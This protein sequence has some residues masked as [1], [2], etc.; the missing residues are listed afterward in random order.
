MAL[1]ATSYWVNVTRAAIVL[2]LSLSMAARAQAAPSCAAPV[3]TD[4]EWEVASPATSGLDPAML[5]AIS[6]RFTAWSAANIHAVLVSRHGKLVF[7]QYFTGA[8]ERLGH[9]AGLIA[10]DATTKHDL[11]SISKSVTALVLGIE[12][13]KRAIGGIDQPVLAAFP[14][15]ADLRSPEK[16]RVTLRHLLTMSSGLAWNEDLPYSNPAN[17]ETR[18]DHAP[19]P[20]RFALEQPVEAPAGAVYNYDSGSTI[21]IAALLKKATGKPID[22]LARDD[23]FGPLGITD[24]EWG[25]FP[26]GEP[27]AASGLRMRPRDLMKIGQLVLDHGAWKG[28]QIVPDDWLAAATSPQIQGQQLYFYGYQFWLGRSLVRGRTIEWVASVGW[29]GQR[30]FIVPALDLVVLVHAGL[31]S[32]DLQ[33][34]VPL[35]IFN[36]YVL[37]AADAP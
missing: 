27:E 11:R 36:R 8:D 1:A 2:A 17:S 35:M 14:E 6:H 29:G 30:L 37:T 23:L 31:Y 25:G 5:C 32:S 13:G 12:L 26:T 24:F 16:D 4:D 22:I 18:M 10:F 19:N 20:V 9:Y 34:W 28:R 7:E 15:Y 21:I 33:S 3:A